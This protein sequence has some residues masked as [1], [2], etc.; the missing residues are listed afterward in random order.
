MKGKILRLLRGKISLLLAAGI[1]IYTL[2]ATALWDGYEET[3]TGD[4]HLVN[5]DSYGSV[6]ST[7][8]PVST[9]ERH[10]HK[11]SMYWN[12]GNQVGAMYL[13]LKNTPRDWSQY[14]SLDMWIYSE[15]PTNGA[16]FIIV[17]NCDQESDSGESYLSQW[18]TTNWEGWKKLSIPIPE[19]SVQRAADSKKVNSIRLANTGWSLVAKPEC[20]LYFGEIVLR[21]PGSS[22][23]GASSLYDAE[24]IAA[25]NDA[26][27]EGY[28]LYPGSSKALT[29]EGQI[30]LDKKSDAAAMTL[31]GVTAAPQSFF[32][33]YLGAKVTQ[34]GGAYTLT[35]GEHTYTGAGREENAT[36]YFPVAETAKALGF[37]A[38]EKDGLVLCG[39][40]TAYAEIANNT[41]L[42][43]VAAYMTC[44]QT[45]APESLTPE[46]YKL[47]RDKWRANLVGDDSVDWSNETVAKS[48]KQ[49]EEIGFNSWQSMNKGSD[50]EELWG[51]LDVTSE[52]MREEYYRISEM[53]IAWGMRGSSLYH[54]TQLRDDILYALEWMYKNRYGQ[55]QMNGRGWKPT[56]DDN[57]WDWQIGAPGALVE[58]LMIMESEVDRATISKY[59]AVCDFYVKGVRE[60]GTNRMNFSRN[61]LGSGLLQEKL[62]RV[63]QGRDGLDLTMLYAEGGKTDGQ[64]FYRDG[65][66]IYHVHHPMNGMYGREHFEKYVELFN[67]LEGTKFSLCSPQKNNAYDWAFEAYEPL[68]YKGDVFRFVM[69][70]DGN[71]GRN[72]AHAVIKTY[73]SMLD[74]APEDIANRLKSI[75]KY[76]AT[77]DTTFDYSS[78]LTLKQLM[79]YLQI[80]E[81]DSIQPRKDYI[82]NKMYYNMDKMV[83]QHEDYAAGISMMSSR[84]YDYESINGANLT[85][86]YL[87]DGMTYLYTENDLTQYD[88]TYWTSVDP[89][90]LP[91]TTVN[92]GERKEIG[93][94]MENAYLSSQDFVG[95]VTLDG[96]YG[97]AAM[98]LESYHGDG[99]GT[100][101][102]TTWQG[103][104]N[105]PRDCTLEAQKAWFLFDDEVV[106]LGSNVHAQDGLPVLTMVENRKSNNMLDLVEMPSDP[107]PV[108]SVVASATPEADNVAENT[109]DGDLST[110][111]AAEND[112]TITWDLGEP[113]ELGIAALA[114]VGESEQRQTIFDLEVSTDGEK[115]EQVFSGHSA[116]ISEKPR[117]Y[118]L[119]G[120]TARYVRYCGHGNTTN[121]WNSILEASF[122]P[123]NPDGSIAIPEMRRIGKEAVTVD[124]KTIA[125]EEEDTALDGAS[126]V[127]LEGTGGYY[128]PDRQNIKARKTEG[129]VGF[130][131]LWLDHGVDPQD[132]TYS[133]VLLPNKSP[134]ETAVYAQN[135][136][137]E[138][139]V[140]TADVQAVRE[141]QLGVTGY[142]FWK[143]GSY[144]GITVSAPMIVMV[145]DNGDV[146]EVSACDPTQ[147]LTGGTV[148]INR[149]LSEVS[150]DEGVTVTGGTSTAIA[151]DFT[152]SRGKSFAARLTEVVSP[153]AGKEQ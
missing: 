11:Y 107:Y 57:W 126:W 48:V 119:G 118:T 147:K 72:A 133:Y 58:I 137:I 78:N 52:D 80:M 98:Y 61:I 41:T 19:L 124:G 29:A 134:E 146:V 40:G 31:D 140:N 14:E 131:E 15:R 89:Y 60:A 9:K 101:G 135:P 139:L 32:E 65:S 117:A 94:S 35:A 50:I 90:R 17:V 2:P 87:S 36:V 111:W 26:L 127:Q 145:K 54:N 38:A 109:I 47:V 5:M 7:G 91:G 22:V 23:G 102:S 100:G 18:V 49:K 123:S 21:A 12:H 46:D 45:P 20:E 34:E 68:I 99:I 95:G 77:E 149:P 56:K 70:R 88:L 148:T 96:Q 55:D 104:P 144:D 136:D 1:L 112:A 39:K 74:S 106:A 108:V 103:G 63:I 66:Y 121:S 42:N 64:G 84:I 67:L 75:I 43:E 115:W 4:V 110:R 92:T 37:E 125:L 69:G 129:A 105:P 33:T 27:K 24:D 6:A 132:G 86:W 120:K 25:V 130:F 151:L 13:P 141:K 59:L 73:V 82:L 30:L 142:V 10:G 71:S 116:G 150:A 122:Y 51:Q 97:T 138:V 83:H 8:F 143:A 44:Y 28:G 152:G 85:G 128:F 16:S 79:N 76:I 53:A 81:D 62:D 93:I 3:V 113:Q 153:A 114:F